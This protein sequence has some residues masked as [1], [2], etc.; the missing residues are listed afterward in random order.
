MC[1]ENQEDY[2]YDPDLEYEGRKIDEYLEAHARGFENVEQ[3]M[4]HD[5]ARELR[6]LAEPGNGWNPEVAVL[7]I[8]QLQHYALMLSMELSPDAVPF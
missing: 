2:E 5:A 8:D 4:I 6:D 3:M 1:G 7:V